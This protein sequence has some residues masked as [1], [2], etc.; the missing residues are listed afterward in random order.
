MET[1][2]PSKEE[3]LADLYIPPE[4]EYIAVRKWKRT[5]YNKQWKSLALEQKMEALKE[6]IGNICEARHIPRNQWPV[7]VVSEHPWGYTHQIRMITMG[8]DTPSVIS[9]LHELGHYLHFSAYLPGEESMTEFVACRYAV[10]IFKTCFPKSYA[11]LTWSEH[12]LVVPND[13]SN[14]Q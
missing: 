2:Y 13:G 4:N 9:T 7:P 14:K 1:K 3:I 11:K 8:L 6:L 12:T 5:F 10:G